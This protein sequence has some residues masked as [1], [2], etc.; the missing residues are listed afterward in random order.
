MLHWHHYLQ[1]ELA[2][3]NLLHHFEWQSRS[4]V[5]VLL[6]KLMSWLHI[7]FGEEMLP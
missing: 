3:L 6:D 4:V 7:E 1:V 5:L 2:I